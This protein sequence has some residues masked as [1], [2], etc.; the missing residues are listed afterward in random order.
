M[1]KTEGPKLKGHR[2]VCYMCDIMVVRKWRN[3]KR[4]SGEELLLGMLE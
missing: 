2:A 3:I 1:L 4:R